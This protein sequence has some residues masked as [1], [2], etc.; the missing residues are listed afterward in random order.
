M[1]INTDVRK[2]G[3]VAVTEARKPWLAAV[4][5]TDLAYGQIRKQLDE[6]PAELR[7]VR[8]G[9]T[10][11]DVRS[12]ATTATGQVREVAEAYVS[13]AREAY[14]TLAHRGDLVVRRIRRRPEVREA[15][16]KTEQALSDAE[17]TV[18]QAEEKVTRPTRKTA[19][20]KTTPR[21]TAK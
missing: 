21:K 5:A 16:A 14:E 1:S 11:L 4:G 9:A 7:R 12:A 10:K 13:T 15:F 17:K 20:R 6:L 2:Y 18:A 8:E 19:P 3:E